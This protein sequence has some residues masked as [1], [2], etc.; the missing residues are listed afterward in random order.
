MADTALLLAVPLFAAALIIALSLALDR[1][2]LKEFMFQSKLQPAS[3]TLNLNY[4]PFPRN[5]VMRLL[6]GLAACMAIGLI[7]WRCVNI[8]RCSLHAF[9]RNRLVRTFLGASREH[10]ERQANPFTGFDAA[11]DFKMHKLWPP[12]KDTG[13]QPF[14]VINTTL[15]IVSA[16]KRGWQERKAAPFTVSPLHCGTGIK[17]TALNPKR[18]SKKKLGA[19]RRSKSYGGRST[20]PGQPSGISVG[21]AMAISGAAAS[22]NM[23]YHSS[24]AVTFLMTMFN[25]RLGWW[26]GN[27]GVEG[28]HTHTEEGPAT[29]IVPLVYELFGL[30]TDDWKYVY[31]SDG[32]HFENLGL[33]E[34]VR[35]RCRFILISDAGCD[36][37]F[38]FEDLG[39]AVRKISIDLNVP[40]RFVK[41]ERLRKRPGDGIMLDGD[42]CSYHAIGETVALARL[43]GIASRLIVKLAM[44]PP[45][46]RARAA[47][48]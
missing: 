25:V 40:I 36:R 3:E 13:W 17:L 44:A 29:A 42:E 16:K 24:P 37:D 5:E 43:M 32:G 10:R 15:N 23:G 20:Q 34:M 46:P 21:T 41:L 8:N 45:G 2:L 33:Y 35:R 18:D 1:L 7:A 30:T 28:E 38:K 12:E 9:Y 48:P 6:F 19:Y 39:N 47:T 27:P 31:L 11:D 26:L 4:T 22:P 14:Q